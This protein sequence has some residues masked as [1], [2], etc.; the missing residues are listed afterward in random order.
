MRLRRLDLTRYGRFTDYSIDF[1]E[2]EA[3]RPDLH[4]VYGPNEAGKSTA[5]AAF[6]DFLFGIEARSRFNFLHPYSTMR[7]GAQLELSDNVRRLVRVKRAQ[8]SLLD[9][10]DQ[11][12]SDVVILGELAGIDRESYRT[13]FS[14][15]DDTLV[16]G[17]ESI[18]ASKGDLG[19]LLFSASAGLADL[20]RNLV[21]IRLEA[22]RFYKYRARGGELSD[23]K[24]RLA[25]L[26]E[27]REKIDTFAAQYAQLVAVRDRT[28]SQYNAALAERARLNSRIGEI[29]RI[30]NALPRLATL[31]DVRL[32]LVPLANLPEAP[33]GWADQLPEMQKDEIALAIRIQAI[34]DEVTQLSTDLEAVAVDETALAL[35]DRIERLADFRARHVTAEKDIPERRLQLRDID[36]GISGILEKIERKD[37]P[38]PVRLVLGA[39]VVAA[40]RELIEKRSGIEAALKT[41][42]DE[43]S[44]A[45]YRLEEAAA[46]LDEAGGGNEAEGMKAAKVS[47]LVPVVAALRADDHAARRRLAARSRAAQL[48]ILAD[49]LRDLLP[50]Q[51][52]IEK[53]AV[54]KVPD[55]EDM[56]RWNKGVSDAQKRLDRHN[57]DVERLTAECDLLKTECNA[58]GVTGVISDQEAGSVR[59]A[60]E[61]AWASHRRT[62]DEI[63]A[64]AFETA[65]R[66][67]DLITTARLGHTADVAKLHQLSRAL[68]SA[69]SSLLRAQNLQAAADAALQQVRDEI[70]SA[71]REMSLALT[72]EMTLLQL[73]AWLARRNKALE[74]RAAIHSAELDLAGADEDAEAARIKLIDALTR[75]GLSYDANATF[76]ALRAIA[77]AAIDREVE[78]KSLRDEVGERRRDLRRREQDVERVAKLERDWTASW[79]ETCDRC[80]IGEA[81]SA[82][83]LRTV[84]EI[85]VALADLSPALEKHAGL[86]DRIG[87]MQK[88][89]EAFAAEVNAIAGKLGIVSPTV[90]IL[91]LAHEV[92][93]RVGA[94]AVAEGNR[95]AKQRSLEATRKRQRALAEDLAVHAK[96]KVELTT[97]FAVTSLADVGVK[98]Q[99]IERKTQ[100]QEQFDLAARDIRNVLRAATI[101]EAEHLLEGV[102]EASL[103]TELAQLKPRFDDQDQRSRALFSDHSKAADSVEAVG[104]DDAVARIEEQRRTT[105]LE[106]EEKALRYLKLRLGSAAAEHALRAYREEHRSSMMAR[107]SEAF[108][109]IS[110]ETYVSLATQPDKDGDMLIA[111]GADGRSKVASELSRGARFQLYLALRVAGYYEF[112]KA[113]QPAPFV[114]D[115]IMESFDD[116]RAEE[117]FRLFAEMA[118]VGQ[119]IYLT[120][121][122]HLCEIAGRVCPGVHLH[123]LG[124]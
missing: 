123:S 103:E 88:D 61:Q 33:I 16:A 49:R 29:E 120:H 48:Q 38:E 45:R 41:A 50:W 117:A 59:M 74:V 53:L 18:L 108:R 44:A 86:T 56:A 7:I 110:R 5:F 83:K 42:D 94:A 22:D 46:K 10:G 3:N 111:V 75:A 25:T 99:S 12:V 90:A 23:L 115:D 67:D 68:A 84:R 122:R 79:V 62:L 87:K 85:L 55:A 80:W 95:V 77:E 4:I 20:S 72:D 39:S 98:L 97:F 82:P 65:L 26:K 27:E 93:E 96:R 70:V 60:R 113:R 106:I 47:S 58:I 8:N 51:G 15:D 104:G 92:E 24:G 1:G 81:G 112:A 119:V 101:D 78:M 2:R 107:A 66:H 71:L 13:M 30:L 17:G 109:T 100:L 40:L 102:D 11:P 73:E 37:D 9:A 105:Q 69:K 124:A 118:A 43:V 6:L 89:Q 54:E 64:N 63:S 52:T 35:S 19:Q 121:H 114:A 36:L 91:D 21:E 32:R 116:F 14:L 34:E 57:A 28:L 31:R 76:D